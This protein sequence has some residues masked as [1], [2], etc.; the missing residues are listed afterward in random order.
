MT[1]PSALSDLIEW[2]EAHAATVD[3]LKWIIVGLLAWALGAFRFMR[4]KLRR[5]KLEIESLTSRCIWQELGTVDGNDH[6]ARVIF[7]IEAG[8][9]NPTTDSLVVRDFALKVKRLK[10]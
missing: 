7:L 5:P 1:F 8:I 4:E 3:L 10:G 6:N 2:I 9:N